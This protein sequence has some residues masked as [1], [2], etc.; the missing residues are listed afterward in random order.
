ML[1]YM[2]EIPAYS[3]DALMDPLPGWRQPAALPGIVDTIDSFGKSNSWNPV[4]SVSVFRDNP[5]A[6]GEIQTLTG[7]RGRSTT[8]EDVVSTLTGQFPAEWLAPMLENRQRYV[9]G[10]YPRVAIGLNGPDP[11]ETAVIAS[12]S[13]Q[14]EGV[15]NPASALP[16][17]VHDVLGRKLGRADLIC[18]QS[19]DEL[20]T[21]SLARLA[22]GV[23]YTKDNKKGLPQFE[24]LITVGVAFMLHPHHSNVFDADYH[25]RMSVLPPHERRYRSLGWTS[26]NSFSGAVQKRDAITLAPYTTEGDAATVCV[27]GQC[28]AMTSLLI[29]A[30]DLL[31]HLGRRDMDLLDYGVPVGDPFA[32]RATAS[33]KR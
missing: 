33:R 6:P 27:R 8:H 12:Y 25:G 10:E 20:G 5:D 29:D 17:L 15:P 26:I 30:P 14:L 9:V 3:S 31:W 2:A 4:L 16:F 1:L 24:R 23:S 21:V 19:D 13:P 7:I 28:L 18:M 22:L 32:L 11:R